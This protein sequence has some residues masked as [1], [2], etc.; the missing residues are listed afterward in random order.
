MTRFPLYLAKHLSLFAL[1]T[2]LRETLHKNANLGN[3]DETFT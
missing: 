2:N 3:P 1:K